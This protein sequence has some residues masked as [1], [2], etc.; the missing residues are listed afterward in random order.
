MW[1]AIGDLNGPQTDKKLITAINFRIME[2]LMVW[3]DLC[4]DSSEAFKTGRGRSFRDS[5]K[6]IFFMI[7]CCLKHRTMWDWHVIGFNREKSTFTRMVGKILT[8]LYL[9]FM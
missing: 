2:F 7:P 3:N 1:E 5:P 6:D 4:D 9:I 8:V